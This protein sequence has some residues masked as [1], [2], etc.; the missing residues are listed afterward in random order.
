MKRVFSAGIIVYT[1]KDKVIYYLLL[2]YPAGHWEFPK[3]KIEG[4]ES[5]HVAAVRELQEETGLTAQI[6]P[7]FEEQFSYYLR[8]REGGVIFKTVF[9]FVGCTKQEQ[10][11]ISHEHRGSA[12][13][14]YEEA[15][16]ELTYQNAKDLLQKA[17]SFLQTQR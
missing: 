14:V 17:H 7:G 15:L 9:F 6:Q 2:H 13:M 4:G 10:V 3:G 8:D 5:K 1:V 11:T 12:W 16:H